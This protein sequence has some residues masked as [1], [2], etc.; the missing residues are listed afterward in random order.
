[1]CIFVRLQ[2]TDTIFKGKYTATEEVNYTC[3]IV[4]NIKNKS[5]NVLLAR[6]TEYSPVLNYPSLPCKGSE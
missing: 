6:W 4:Y 3:I 2:R 1:M 5:V